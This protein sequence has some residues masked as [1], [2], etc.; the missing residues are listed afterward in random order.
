M[1][2][3]AEKSQP[4]SLV[5]HREFK[6]LLK[7]EKFPTRRALLQ[8]NALLV[9]VSKK[10]GVK[11][12]P[13]ES[14]D[15]QL[16]IVQFYDTKNEDLRKNKL[17]F[18]I[19]QIREGGWPDDSWELTFKCR[20]PDYKQAAGFDTNTTYTQLQKK[21]FKEE[22]I[23]GDVP[24]TMASIYSNNVIVEYPEVQ[25]SFPISRLANALPHLKT[26]GLDLED[27]LAIV[28]GAKVFEIQSTLGNF[29]FGHG[30]NAHATLALWARP[31]PDRFE[32]LV[33]E[34]GFSTRVLGD[35]EKEEKAQKAADDFFKALQL[36]LRDYLSDGTTKTALIYGDSGA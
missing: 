35:D 33:A 27:Q 34:F 10:L 3:S 1:N 16:R 7:P 5:T 24:G 22:L 8:F 4:A 12:E 29:S 21:K 20:T 30:V 14:L 18:R 9:D 28:N 13:V 23:R 19:R 2:K 36:P 31:I 25:E 17:I 15:S 26:V 11:Y 6:L 32:P